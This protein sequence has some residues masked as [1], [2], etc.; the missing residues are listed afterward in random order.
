MKA[1]R[2]AAILLAAGLTAALPG[3][4]DPQGK[5]RAAAPPAETPRQ[6]PQ[7]RQQNAPRPQQQP[8][9]PE[10]RA[11]AQARGD[12]VFLKLLNMTPDEREK[13]LSVLPPE[14]RAQFQK[15]IE[16]FQKLD[17]TVQ[18][19]RLGRVEKLNALPIDQQARVRQSMK[20]LQ[21]LPDDRKKALNQ[22]LRRMASM[23]DDEK[24]S[25][26]TS[27]EFRNRFSPAEQEMLG[28]ITK[29]F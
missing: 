26:M 14:R 9:N 4:A 7:P 13:A 29:V 18:E 1:A 24:Q 8:R 21:A 2:A 20:D 15:R 28:N 5:G 17:P 16:N 10:T 3:F 11:K 19:R 23:S 25:R 6:A 12:E 27:D 22:E